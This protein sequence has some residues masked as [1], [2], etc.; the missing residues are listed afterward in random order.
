MNIK[1]HHV[2]SALR[3][4]IAN[5]PLYKNIGINYRLLE[6]WDNKFIPS[7]IMDTMVH[8]DSNQHKQQGYTT[9]LCN[10]NFENELDAF[11]A[12]IRIKEDHINSGCIYSNIDDRRQN[13]NICLLSVIGNIKAQAPTLDSS[14]SDIVIF[15]M[16]DQLVLLNN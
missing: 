11:I 16:R 7:D 2:I 5:N 15:C 4:L 8:C 12:S 1:K 6:T 13:L 10:G 9:D 14:R 3:W